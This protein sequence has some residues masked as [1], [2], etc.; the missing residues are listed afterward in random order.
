MWPRE[1]FDARAKSSGKNGQE[2][3]KGK[4]ILAGT[5]D[6][7]T[8]NPG[9]YILYRNEQPHYIG[10]AE[11]RL[12][13]RLWAHA[14]TPRDKFYH[15]W[16]HFSAF[17][18]SDVELRRELEGILIATMPTANSAEPKLRKEAMPAEVAKLMQLLRRGKLP[19]RENRV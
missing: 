8:Q 3:K 1:I 10:K 13:D 9:V 18:V 7:L 19:S 11:V 16:T 5:L 6:F 15:F 4:Q 12:Y 2:G 17:A 14:N